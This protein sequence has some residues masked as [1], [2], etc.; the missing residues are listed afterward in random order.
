MDNGYYQPLKLDFELDT[1]HF[2]AI[3]LTIADPSKKETLI[4]G[5]AF[6][7]EVLRKF[8]ASVNCCIIQMT[9]FYTPAG[10]SRVI[11]SDNTW[12][13]NITKLN[14][15]ING[16]GSVMKWWQLKEK[17][18]EAR[19]GVLPNGRKY[20]YFSADQCDLVAVKE[21]TGPTMV[22]VGALHSV[23]NFTD[24]NRWA[25][26]YTLGDQNGMPLQWNEAVKIFQPY[27]ATDLN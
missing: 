12:M 15:V 4:M 23:E 9:Y 26:S 18:A 2:E 27:F 17:N 10:Q 22:N 7:D 13:D 25:I 24:N 11:H 14:F 1:S 8:V 16:S 20:N 6:V 3:R 21:L 5:T 19:I